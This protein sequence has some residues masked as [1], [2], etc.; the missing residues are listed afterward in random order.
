MKT[1]LTKYCIAVYRSLGCTERKLKVQ[2]YQTTGSHRLQVAIVDYRQPQQTSGSQRRL[3]IAIV[4]Y[5]QVWQTAGS[6]SR[7]LVGMQLQLWKTQESQQFKQAKVMHL[8]DRAGT[9]ASLLLYKA[10]NPSVCLCVCHGS[11]SAASA[12]IETGLAQN[13]S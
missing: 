4:Y 8:Q 13:E 7:L 9:L 12:S 6:H 2:S 11:I 5:R 1:R 10:E 3:Q